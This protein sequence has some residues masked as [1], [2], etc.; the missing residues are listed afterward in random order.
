MRTKA[1][2][3]PTLLYVGTHDFS[4]EVQEV[5]HFLRW[6]ACHLILVEP[7]P[8]VVHRMQQ[9]VNSSG[10]SSSSVHIVNAALCPEDAEAAQIHLP[11]GGDIVLSEVASLSAEHLAQ[12]G[13][14]SLRSIPTRCLTPSRLL[15]ELALKPEALD[16][17][18]IDT[19]GYDAELAELFLAS[20]GFSPG[21]LQLEYIFHGHADSKLD[22]WARLSSALA[23]RGYDVFLD[24][25]D[26]VAVLP[27]QL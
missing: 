16:Y 2:S 11:A 15:E 6:G 27:G 8:E 7:N 13:F 26:M 25:V 5:K 19:E 14:T 10:I 22:R 23:M 9:R 20:D 17:V 12:M 18:K 24:D 3:L 21:V 4:R 1:H